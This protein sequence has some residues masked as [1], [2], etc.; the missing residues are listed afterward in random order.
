MQ[1]LLLVYTAY[2]LGAGSPG[3]SNMAIMNVAMQQGRRSALAL[4]GGVIS[5]SA[6]WGVIAATGM[7]ALLMRYT[8]ALTILKI[9]GGLYLLWLAYK[10][11]R[12]AAA[13]QTFSLAAAAPAR[14][15]DRY[16]QG[17]LLHL[18][19]PKAVLAWMAVM[20]LGLRPGAPHHMILI[21]LGGCILL[22]VL[23]F[24]GYA[25]LFSTAPMVRGYARARRWIEATFA[26]FF[27]GAGVRLL[28]S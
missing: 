26:I 14:C 18:G 13:R 10:A 28:L 17:V 16:R 2:V 4:A 12:S 22:G 25:L 11:F 8:Q 23:I 27:G 9:G 7:S 24:A 1:E 3:P 20:S 21:A 6:V 5:M 19:N 15:R